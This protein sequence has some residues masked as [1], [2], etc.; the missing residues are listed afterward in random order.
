MTNNS[1]SF[2][3]TSKA[4]LQDPEM[5]EIYLKEVFESGDIELLKLALRDVDAVE[6]VSL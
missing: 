1:R 6:S 5:V 3:Q 4:L 2:D